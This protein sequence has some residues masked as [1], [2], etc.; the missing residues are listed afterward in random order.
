MTLTTDIIQTEADELR[1]TGID[2]LQRNHNEYIRAAKTHLDCAT[3]IQRF[4]PLP[5]GFCHAGWPWPKQYW[6]PER[7][8]AQKHVLRAAAFMVLEFER[9]DEQNE[10][11]LALKRQTSTTDAPA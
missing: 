3:V 2:Q 6:H 4:G 8:D 11:F 5:E 10:A 7:F 1:A 9:I